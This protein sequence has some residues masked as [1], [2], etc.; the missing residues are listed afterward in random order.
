MTIVRKYSWAGISKEVGWE[1]FGE[2]LPKKNIVDYWCDQASKGS[3]DGIVRLLSYHRFTKN[4][5]TRGERLRLHA[6][7]TVLLQSRA[8]YC[9]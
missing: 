2:E 3:R 5:K 9:E 6:I 8:K 4:P 7:T 1:G